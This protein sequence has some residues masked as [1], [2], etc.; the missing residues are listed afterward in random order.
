MDIPV[1]V[2]PFRNRHA[3]LRQWLHDM[4]RVLPRRAIRVVVEQCDNQKFNRGALLNVGFERAV[5]LGARRVIFHDVDLV[6]TR[7]LARM[8]FDRWP[9]PVVHFGAR[10]ARYNNSEH[11]F[12]GVVGYDVDYFPGFSN[13]FYGWGGE[14]DSLYRR[15]CKNLISRPQIGEY[16]DL[17]NMPTV[18]HKLNSL[19]VRDKC[20]NKRELLRCDDAQNDNHHSLR[21]V[22]HYDRQHGAEW[23]HVRLPKSGKYQ[24]A[25]QGGP[26][27]TRRQLSAA[28][29]R[30]PSA[31]LP[32]WSPE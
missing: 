26:R 25:D 10:F 24:T 30:G 29:T 28:E 21:C 23:L 2:I 13:K 12:G 1:I 5:Q 27:T 32:K 31:Q 11:Y 18:K 9:S 15:T 17:E 22:K 6:P 8:Y 4:H 20:T 14:D 16:R 19:R 7:D 3:H